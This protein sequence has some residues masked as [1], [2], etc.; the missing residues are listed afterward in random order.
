[1]TFLLEP[2]KITTL[3]DLGAYLVPTQPSSRP[4]PKK[5]GRRVIVYIHY[6]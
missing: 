2:V 1:M 5:L 4:G 6:I 3:N